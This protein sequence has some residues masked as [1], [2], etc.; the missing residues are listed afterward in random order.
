VQPGGSTL[1]AHLN[2]FPVTAT[3]F[4][5]IQNAGTDAVVG[6]FAGL[7]EGAT[8]STSRGNLRIS[9]KGGDGNDVVLTAVVTIRTTNIIALFPR[10]GRPLHRP[11]I[12]TPTPAPA[13]HLP[14][15]RKGHL[16]RHR[17][18]RRGL[19]PT[20]HRRPWPHSVLTPA[21]LHASRTTHRKSDPD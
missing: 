18:F 15:S 16:D 7:P 8:I 10:P 17:G 13:R 2:F 14:R 9:Y 4:I 21:P 19:R 12:A 11:A 1:I 3:S 6:T 5:I 20:D